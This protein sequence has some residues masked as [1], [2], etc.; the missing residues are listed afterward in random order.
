M[1]RSTARLKSQARGRIG[2]QRRGTAGLDFLTRR[3]V[4]DAAIPE[5][6]VELDFLGASAAVARA[7][8]HTEGKPDL[9]GAL[10]GGDARVSVAV[11]ADHECPLVLGDRNL[12]DRLIAPTEPTAAH[13]GNRQDDSRRD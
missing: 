9:I 13:E 2:W 5:W 6:L 12:A 3:C 1:R 11:V 4:D 7:P 10:D 8:V